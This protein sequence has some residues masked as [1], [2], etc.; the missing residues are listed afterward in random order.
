VC[1]RLVRGFS[2]LLVQCSFLFFGERLRV[3]FLWRPKKSNQKTILSGTKWDARSAPVGFAPWKA[4]IKGRPTTCPLRGYPAL[5]AFIA[6]TQTRYAQTRV[7]SAHPCA[8]PYGQSVIV[9]NGVPAVSSLNPMKAAML[10]CIEGRV[11][12]K[13]NPKTTGS[14][15]G[16]KDARL[17]RYLTPNNYATCSIRRYSSSCFLM[18]CCKS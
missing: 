3:T 1:S 2:A 13:P 17:F 18:V 15:S 8:S 6:R 5:L 16:K 12:Q 11:N 14:D 7:H 9:R 10:G 4:Q